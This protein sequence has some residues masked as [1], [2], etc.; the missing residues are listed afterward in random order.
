MVSDSKPIHLLQL[1]GDFFDVDGVVHSI[2]NSDLDEV[3]IIDQFDS[4][5]HFEGTRTVEV[6]NF[7]LFFHD[8]LF[9]GIGDLMILTFEIPCFAISI[10]SQLQVV[11]VSEVTGGVGD[12]ND[13]R[14]LL[15]EVHIKLQIK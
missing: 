5:A 6:I 3:G 8:Y 12:F 7:P 4:F 11:L 2:F 14:E 13:D 1:K 15:D 10:D 9:E